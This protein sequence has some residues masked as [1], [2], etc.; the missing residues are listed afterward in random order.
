MIYTGGENDLTR[1]MVASF[2]VLLVFATLVI[3]AHADNEEES[4]IVARV[5]GEEI[6]KKNL[7]RSAGIQRIFLALKGVPEFAEFLMGTEQGQRALDAYRSYVLEKLI[8]EKLVLQKAKSR[9]I[10]VNNREVENRLTTIINRTKEVANKEELI[11]KLEKDQRSL[12]DL[13]EEIRRKLV[14]EKLRREIVGK[15]EVSESEIRNYYE[16]N[17]DSFRDKDGV[18]KPLS[19]VKEQ[20]REKLREDKKTAQWN[21]WLEKVKKEAKI[22]RA[23]KNDG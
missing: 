16:K 17:K 20:I 9:G 1:Y 15:V 19:E 12:E 5:N 6:T 18:V 14:R 8:D 7:A 11:K 3:S 21:E 22:V 23:L 13:K 2:L 4:S 10:E